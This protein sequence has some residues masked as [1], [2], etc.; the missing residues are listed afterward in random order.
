MLG[1]EFV[2]LWDVSEDY[3]DD[4]NVITYHLVV[5]MRACGV[6]V[7]LVIFAGLWK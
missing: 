2:G 4:G 3:V 7:L 5:C 1:A 6:V